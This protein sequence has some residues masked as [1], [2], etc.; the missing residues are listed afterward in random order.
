MIGAVLI[1]ETACLDLN[2]IPLPGNDNSGHVEDSPAY[3]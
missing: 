2:E 3:Y 1:K